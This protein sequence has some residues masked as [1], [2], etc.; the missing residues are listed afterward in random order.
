MKRP[1]QIDWVSWVIGTWW[2]SSV[3]VVAVVV[4]DLLTGDFEG[5]DE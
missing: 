4:R 5:A 3:V 2:L 1:G